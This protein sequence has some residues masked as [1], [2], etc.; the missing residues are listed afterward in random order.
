MTYRIAGIDVHKKVLAVVVADVANAGEYEFEGQTFGTS[1]QQLRE[2]AEWLIS[3]QAQ[4][5]VMES[6]AQYWRPVWEALE[7]YWQ[8]VVRAPAE[9]TSSTGNLHLAQ[10]LSNRGRRGRKNDFEDAKRLVRRLVAQELQL[11]FVPEQH[12]RLWRTVSR[13]KHQLRRQKV[14]LQNQLECLLEEGHIKLSSLVSDLLGVSGRRMLEALAHGVSDPAALAALGATNLR[15]TAEQLHDALSAASELSPVY[16]RLLQMY[17]EELALLER[18][19]EKLQQELADLMEPY[20]QAVQRLAEVPGLGVDSAHQIIAE[21]GPAA[22]AFPSAK[23]LSSWVGVCPGEEVSAEICRSRR[24]PKGN[25]NMRRLLDQAAQAA[26]KSRGSIFQ[27]KFQQLRRRGLP[28]QSAVWAIAHRLC[29]LIWKILRQGIR[30]EERGPG[31][32]ANAQRRRTARMIREL[33]K[34]GYSVQPPSPT[35]ATA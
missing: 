35:P 5:A 25:R 7:R 30:Y 16:R 15:A 3:Q 10:G 14:R 27:I 32:A 28:Y 22:D 29:R 19:M 33:R 31:L 6:T 9:T 18:Q 2:L 8:K 24:S 34:R 26:V 1:P 17:L 12:Q 20:Q 13:K 21:V 11:S 4:E 23:D